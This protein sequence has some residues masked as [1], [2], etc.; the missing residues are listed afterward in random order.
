MLIIFILLGL[1]FGSFLNVLIYRLPRDLSVI[2]PR[3]FCTY[4]SSTILWY[5]N[6]PLLSFIFL[7]GKSYCC[8][9]KIS[10]QYPIVEI[11]SSLLWVW[12]YYYIDLMSYQI[13]FL[14]I[15]SCLLVIIFTDFIHFVVPI[16]LNLTMFLSC[17]FIY[18]YNSENI[19]DSLYS[20]SL[21]GIYFL[22][23]MLILGFFLKKEALGYGDIILIAV[24]SFWLGWI[25]AFIIVFFSSFL[26][27]IHWFVLTLNSNEKDIKLP[28]GSSIAFI[29]IFLYMIKET[30][31]ISTK[32]F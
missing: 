12:S 13:L 7:K 5:C 25:D 1:I 22:L 10:I 17:F 32:L 28:F 6:I 20:M 27:L 3:S 21:L 8:N 26:S 19:L 24:V 30:F 29:S 14:I 15:S 9:K 4:C 18:L 23:L 11:L 31:Q 2:Y 16:E